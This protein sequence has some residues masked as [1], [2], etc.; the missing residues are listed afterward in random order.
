MKI[1]DV[2]MRCYVDDKTGKASEDMF[3]AS[4]TRNMLAVLWDVCTNS[5]EIECI[6]IN[7]E[8]ADIF[9]TAYKL[10]ADETAKGY[11]KLGVEYTRHAI[12]ES[13]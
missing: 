2:E 8:D 7:G 3:E 10:I 5:A 9:E 1:N 12:E 11:E 13:E 6:E 4:V